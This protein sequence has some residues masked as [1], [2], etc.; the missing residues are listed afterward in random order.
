MC[1]RSVIVCLSDY[2]CFI[3]CWG[4]S[5]CSFL[6]VDDVILNACCNQLFDSIACCCNC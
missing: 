3:E 5:G 4:E 6:V 2:D 1:L